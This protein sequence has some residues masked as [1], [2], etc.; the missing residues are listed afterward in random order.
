MLKN[1]TYSY[2]RDNR[3]ILK[4]AEDAGFCLVVVDYGSSEWGP[5]IS[6]ILIIVQ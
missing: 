5:T 3:V 4:K 6:K 1:T 2:S